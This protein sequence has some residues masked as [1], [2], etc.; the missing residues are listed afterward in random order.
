[1]SHIVY[2]D[3]LDR[4]EFDDG[5]WVDIKRRMSYGDDQALSAHYLK[6]RAK[7]EQLKPDVDVDLNIESGNIALLTLNIKAW[8]FKDKKDKPLP[9]NK[10]TIAMLDRDTS[11]RIVSE[12]AKRNPPPKA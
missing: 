7:L 6:I 3:E 5:E 11:T 9:V 1:M 8:S 2:E 4:I 12:I 10:T